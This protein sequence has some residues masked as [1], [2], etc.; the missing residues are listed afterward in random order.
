MNEQAHCPKCHGPLPADAWEGLCPQCLPSHRASGLKI[1]SG[2]LLLLLGGIWTLFWGVV[3]VSSIS[4]TDRGGGPEAVGD[5]VGGAMMAL[6][7][8]FALAAAVILIRSAIKP[9]KIRG[10][11][12]AVS[13]PVKG[14]LLRRSVLGGVIG[15]AVASLISMLITPAL[16]RYPISEAPRAYQDWI[17]IALMIVG[18]GIPVFGA[19]L[20]VIV[21]RRTRFDDTSSRAR[22]WASL[23]RSAMGG[24]VGAVAS[25]LTWLFLP[26]IL[27]LA[28]LYRVLGVPYEYEDLMGFN[29]GLVSAMM[30]AVGATIG[31]VM[32]RRMGVQQEPTAESELPRG[33][34]KRY[35]YGLIAAGVV[36][37]LAAI[38]FWTNAPKALVASDPVLGVRPGEERTFAGIPFCWCP[39]GTF[40]MGSPDS[41]AGRKKNEGPQHAVTFKQG[42]WMSKY[43]VTHAQWKAIDGFH[44]EAM[45]G[46]ENLPM[47]MIDWYECQSFLKKLSRKGAGVFRLPSEAEWEYACR[48]GTQTPFSFGETL[49]KNQADWDRGAPKAV[50][51]FVG[52]AWNLC[53][54]HGGVREWCQDSWHEEYTGAPNDGSAWESP[55]DGDRV[56]RSGSWDNMDRGTTDRR[57]ASRGH[58][59]PGMHALELGFRIVRTP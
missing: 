57:S 7:G 18:N 39:A 9:P 52:N 26:P 45:K 29:L 25:F 16:V 13:H 35:R 43:E 30:L 17:R 2:I 15:Y 47:Q 40:M 48:A 49:S 3:V 54:M 36:A 14:A 44:P 1:V 53:G 32:A 27:I 34:H 11:Q 28:A 46:N 4:A 6:F 23:G 41:E 5:A 19:V 38:L 55:G 12:D 8:L 50:D 33:A 20:G 31:V 22:Q 37:F 58:A 51:A 24:A 56:F 10:A 59:M 21:A 42:F